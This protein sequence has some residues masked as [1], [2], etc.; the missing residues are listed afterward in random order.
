MEKN[1]EKNFLN[2]IIMQIFGKTKVAKREFY[3]AK[4]Q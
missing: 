4:K 3:G 2:S 1:N